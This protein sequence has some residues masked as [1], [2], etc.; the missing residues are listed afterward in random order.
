[1]FCLLAARA[2]ATELR[3]VLSGGGDPKAHRERKRRA[4]ALED[5]RTI[6]F[7]TAARRYHERHKAKWRSA[8][9]TRQ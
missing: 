5:A 1:M 6:T 2:E 3:V 4:K 9:H 7:E 8:V